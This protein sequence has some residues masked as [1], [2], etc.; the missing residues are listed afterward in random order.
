MHETQTRMLE[1][2]A[3]R[4]ITN[5]RLAD[6]ARLLDISSLQ[7]VKHHRDQLIKGGLLEESDKT[8]NIRIIKNVLN[9][10]DLISV[11]IL[12]SA[13]A[14]PASI[15]SDWVVEGY[16]QISSAL[17]PAKTPREKLFALKVVGDSMNNAQVNGKYK[18]EDKDYV[19][20]DARPFTPKNGDYVVTYF[21]GHKANI[22]RFYRTEDSDQIALLS[23]STKDYSPIIVSKEDSL[24]N[25]TQAK[26]VTV[27]KT[28]KL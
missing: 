3:S 12:G 13:N 17:L 25:L 14:G 24:E 1:L 22:K 19:I 4:D 18:I 2:A 15:Y 6:L 21:S 9:N 8:K 5:M 20:A 23:E 27:A 10:S 28:P 7:K 11:P 26:I 16:I